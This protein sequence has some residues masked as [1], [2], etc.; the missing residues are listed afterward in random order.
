MFIERLLPT[1]FFSGGEKVP[2]AD[3]GVLV[4]AKQWT[5]SINGR[6]KLMTTLGFSARS[7]PSSAC[8]HLLP[9]KK[10][11]GEKALDG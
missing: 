3:E 4:L 10:T 6:G 7:A 11:A 5:I 2:E 8:R 9:R 1:A